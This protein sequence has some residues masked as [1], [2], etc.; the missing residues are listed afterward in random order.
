MSASLVGSEMCIRDRPQPELNSGA[1]LSGALPSECSA[2]KSAAPRPRPG[3]AKA[4]ALGQNGQSSGA[5]C[6]LGRRH[7]PQG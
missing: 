4:Q 5:N 1:L 3:R 7:S 6:E 2:Q